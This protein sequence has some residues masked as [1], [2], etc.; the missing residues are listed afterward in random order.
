MASS[1]FPKGCTAQRPVLLM[2]GAE[3]GVIDKKWQKEST[4]ILCPVMLFCLQVK[5]KLWRKLK[6]FLPCVLVKV[7]QVVTRDEF[8]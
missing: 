1:C 2:Q 5:E 4:S 6:H 8:F 3:V 7:N